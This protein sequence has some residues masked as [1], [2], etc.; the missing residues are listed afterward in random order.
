L[1]LIGVEGLVFRIARFTCPL[2]VNTKMLTTC[3]AALIN[4]A[5]F[6]CNFKFISSIVKA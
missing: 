2:P 3:L 5:N 1:G 4:N 6:G